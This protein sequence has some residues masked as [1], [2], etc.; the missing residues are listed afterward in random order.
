MQQHRDGRAEKANV[1]LSNADDE[2]DFGDE[3]A[4]AEILMDG[5]SSAL[6]IRYQGERDE[7]EEE[8]DDGND[9]AGVSDDG[10]LDV[11]IGEIDEDG[12]KIHEDGEVG[13]MVA[14]AFSM[15]LV[16]VNEA[17]TGRRPVSRGGR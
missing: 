13:E 14:S 3:E 9:A 5:V 6:Q 12:V 15:R 16:G 1:R 10:Q 4:E 11:V 7:R 2:D 17:A 8:S